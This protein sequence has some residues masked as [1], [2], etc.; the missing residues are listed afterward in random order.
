M[1]QE[2]L[3]VALIQKENDSRWKYESIKRNTE[4]EKDSCTGLR[5]EYNGHTNV[6]YFAHHLNPFQR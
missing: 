2:M 5:Y 3:K 6:K 1:L 4:H